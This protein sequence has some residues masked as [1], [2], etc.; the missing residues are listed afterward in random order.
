[1]QRL[2]PEDKSEARTSSSGGQA[3]PKRRT[4][5]L[6]ADTRLEIKKPSPVRWAALLLP[7]ASGGSIFSREIGARH[8]PDHKKNRVLLIN[9]EWFQLRA[10]P[11]ERSP[12][13]ELL[14]PSGTIGSDR[15]DRTFQRSSSS[16]SSG[17]FPFCSS[18]RRGLLRRSLSAASEQGIGRQPCEVFF[19]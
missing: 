17:R 18:R 19:Q 3:V 14:I 1:M 5:K 4:E 8:R 13:A 15:S 6:A 9:T 12:L 11:R 16:T 2:Q 7:E 10:D